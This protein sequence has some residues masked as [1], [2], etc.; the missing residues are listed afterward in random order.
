MWI[1]KDNVHFTYNSIPLVKIK[2]TRL[3]YSQNKGEMYLEYNTCYII[4][5]IFYEDLLK[6]IDAWQIRKK[7]LDYSNVS[8]F[9]FLLLAI[10]RGM[11]K[12]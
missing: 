5:I 7:T 3:T 10:S 9:S 1:M 11:W 12:S 2:D 6:N 8:M 4:Y